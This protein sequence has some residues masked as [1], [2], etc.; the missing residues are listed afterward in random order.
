MMIE[1]ETEVMNIGSERKDK[2]EKRD[3]D[4]S[5]I[6]KH[7]RQSEIYKVFRSEPR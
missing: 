6:E 4:K 5:R 3:M 7:F 1:M 2:F